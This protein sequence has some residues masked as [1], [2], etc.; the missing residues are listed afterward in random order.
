MIKAPDSK[1]GAK[2]SA[3]KRCKRMPSVYTDT[4]MV[5]DPERQMHHLPSRH[6]GT[7]DRSWRWFLELS[8]SGIG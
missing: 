6:Q 7:V 3:P 2:S 4:G 1:T 8:L 5:I